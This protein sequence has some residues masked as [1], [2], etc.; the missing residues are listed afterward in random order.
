MKRALEFTYTSFSR[1]PPAQIVEKAKDVID[2]FIPT[3][4]HQGFDKENEWR[5]IF[6]PS[7][8]IKVKPRYRATKDMLVP[9]FSLKELSLSLDKKTKW[10][11]PIRQVCIGPNR[12]RELNRACAQSLL[13]DNGYKCPVIASDTPYRS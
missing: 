11:L 12:H 7:T 2:F 3:F 5:M 4:K 9:Y 6:V 8:E 10:Q 13:T 1:L